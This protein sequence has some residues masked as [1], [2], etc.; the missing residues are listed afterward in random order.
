MNNIMKRYILVLLLIK[1]VSVN[2]A[3]LVLTPLDR[4]ITN[5]TYN[6]FHKEAEEMIVKKIGE[7]PNDLKYY[8]FYIGNKLVESI[9]AVSEAK[10]SERR[11]VR[12]SLN[13]A[14]IRYCEAIIERFEDRDEN[15]NDKFYLGCFYG[16][17]GRLYGVQGSWMSA[18]SNGKTGKGLLEE[19]IEED[20]EFYDAY[21]LLGMFYYYGDRMGGFISFVASILG[22]SGDRELGLEY[23]RI[24]ENKGGL[25][26]PQAQMILAELYSRLESNK[27]EA[28]PYFE[29]FVKKYPHNKH[30]LNWY[31]RDLAELD[32]IDELSKVIENDKNNLIDD[33]TKGLFFHRVKEFKKSNLHFSKMLT[34]S[35]NLWRWLK[36]DAAFAMAVNS[37]MLN[38]P[39]PDIS[40]LREENQKIIKIIADDPVKFKELFEFQF[41]VTV[42]GDRDVINKFIKLDYSAAGKNYFAAFHQFYTGIYFYRGGNY[43]SAE[44]A[45]RKSFDLYKDDVG[46]K[47][48]LYL[49]SIYEKSNFPPANVEKFVELIYDNELEWLEYRTEDLEEK[50]DI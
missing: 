3:T 44:T 18:F 34:D 17:L 43:K 11:T 20:P 2:S 46:Y 25:T 16:Y 4:E 29:K 30:F 5:L 32:K 31:C 15:I 7:D 14:M 49:F 12:D 28:L 47:S 21:L 8:Y 27:E 6:N 48:I 35:T 38:I 9:K 36:D 33:F 50:Y 24:A 26:V 37:I 39:M 42:T 1:I 45:F 22:F 40:E 19:V 41:A 23:L 13:N 10:S